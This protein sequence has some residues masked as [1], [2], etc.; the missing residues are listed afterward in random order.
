MHPLRAIPSLFSLLLCLVLAGCLEVDG[1]EITIRRDE[2]ADRIDIHV[3]HRGLF[4]ENG[5]GSSNDPMAKAVKDLADVR[6]GGEVVFWCNWPMT[7]DLTR[8]YPAPVQAMLANVDVENGGLFTDPQGLLCGHQFVRIRNATAF[9]KQLNTLLE[10]WVQTQLL[11]GTPGRGGRHQWDDDT[12]E[13]VREFLRSG[14]KLL[15]VET[16]RIEVRLPLSPRDHAWFK[17]QL[18]R[19]VLDGVP[20]EMLRRRRTADHRAAG[21][22]PTDTSFVDGAVTVP[23]EQVRDDLLRAPTNRFLWDNEF[24][25]Q[26]E[27]EL[28]RV[29]LGVAGGDLRVVKASEGLYHPALLNKLREN[30]ESIEDGVPDQELARRFEAFQK[31]DAVLPPK[32]AELRAAAASPKGVPAKPNPGDGK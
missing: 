15:V 31:R 16:G 4:A 27:P 5:Q 21:G 23:G 29:S 8:E 11:G 30:G 13:A 20:R 25:W 28:T 32:V 1:Q 9:V 10:L 26:R 17:N 22:D 14:E 3:V 24:G 19:L 7:F 12:K 2:A 6:A 18:E